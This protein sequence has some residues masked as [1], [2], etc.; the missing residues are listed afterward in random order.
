MACFPHTG[1]GR[2]WRGGGGGWRETRGGG[3]SDKD[4]PLHEPFT[5]SHPSCPP[6]PLVDGSF[7]HNFRSPTFVS[8]L[9]PAPRFHTDT[10]HPSIAAYSSRR[11]MGATAL[12]SAGKV[13][14]QRQLRRTRTSPRTG[15]SSTTDPPWSDASVHRSH[16]TVG[17]TSTRGGHVRIHSS[18]PRIS[19]QYST[20]TE[21]A[22]YSA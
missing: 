16:S 10:R 15:S 11:R 9:S 19:L 2:K 14:G 18:A 22:P 13:S 6:P 3:G 8:P 20:P 21:A 12:T 1:G 7:V 5:Q 17:S 4:T